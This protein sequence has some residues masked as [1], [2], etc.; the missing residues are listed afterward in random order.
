MTTVALTLPPTHW[1]AS[2]D[3]TD[4]REA[5]ARHQFS[6]NTCNGCHFG[7]TDTF[8]L[9]VDPTVMPAALS[10][11]LTGGGGGGVWSVPDPQFGT[12]TWT[13]ADLERRF[14]R[15]YEL[16]CSS[17]GRLVGF[18]PG[19]IRQIVELKE[20]V[21]IDPIGPVIRFPFEVGPIERLETVAQLLERRESFLLKSSVADVALDGAVHAAQRLVH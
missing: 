1:E 5:C 16:A 10:N 11:F 21:P 7:E 2:V 15:L 19:I 8:F 12:P 6:L 4:N 14:S 9:H 3:P 13:F 17:C 20:R 18:D